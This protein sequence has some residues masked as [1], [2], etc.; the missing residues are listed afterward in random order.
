MSK[1]L[2]VRHEVNFHTSSGKVNTQP[3]FKRKP[4]TDV[5][6]AAPALR[7]V[8]AP[9]DLTTQTQRAKVLTEDVLACSLSLS[10]SP[11]LSVS[12]SL[13]FSLSLSVAFSFPTY[14]SILAQAKHISQTVPVASESDLRHRR[15]LLSPRIQDLIA[16]TNFL[17]SPPTSQAWRGRH[18]Q[19]GHQDA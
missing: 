12:V 15:G 2:N 17:P 13:S 5:C 18:P 11:C 7:Q 9:E 4:I 19:M 1:R 6:S 3:F 14:S 16:A 8:P 10:L